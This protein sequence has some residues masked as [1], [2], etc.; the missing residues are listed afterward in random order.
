MGSTREA[1]G[2]FIQVDPKKIDSWKTLWDTLNRPFSRRDFDSE[3]FG[4]EDW[5]VLG[6]YTVF[7]T[8][9]EGVFIYAVSDGKGKVSITVVSCHED[10]NPLQILNEIANDLGGMDVFTECDRRLEG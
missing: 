7:S 6:Y 10:I 4:H 8:I 2:D 9:K 5:G 3:G 1:R